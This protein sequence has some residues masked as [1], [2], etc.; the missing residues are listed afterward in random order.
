MDDSCRFET[1]YLSVIASLGYTLIVLVLLVFIARRNNNVAIALNGAFFGLAGIILG[2][3]IVVILSSIVGGPLPLELD[4]LILVMLQLAS[5]MS[6]CLSR[7]HLP[8]KM[9]F[10]ESDDFIAAAFG[11]SF[12]T[13]G[14][15]SLNNWHP[16]E[17]AFYSIPNEPSQCSDVIRATMSSMNMALVLLSSPVIMYFVYR[18]MY[19][20]TSVR[21]LLSAFTAHAIIAL[22]VPVLASRFGFCAPSLLLTLASICASTLIT[23]RLDLGRFIKKESDDDTDVVRTFFPDIQTAP[24]AFPQRSANGRNDPSSP[25]QQ[26]EGTSWVDQYFT[27][28]GTSTHEGLVAAAPSLE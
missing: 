15:I 14:F 27:S 13:V 9:V 19:P 11:F 22:N 18:G 4:A 21:F 6:F 1:I 12:A 17:C 7:T 3:V 16:G 24:M 20:K 8:W 28:P 23:R 25:R 5:K 10:F 2:S 26:P